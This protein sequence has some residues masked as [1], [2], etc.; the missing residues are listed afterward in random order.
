MEYLLKPKSELYK[1]YILLNCSTFHVLIIV[2]TSL[3][4]PG[5]R[6]ESVD[7]HRVV[8]ICMEE[9]KRCQETSL[10]IAFMALLGDKYGWRPLPPFILAKDLDTLLRYVK[11]SDEAVVREWYLL[12]NNSIPPTYCLQPMSTKFSVRSDNK[13]ERDQA[14]RDWGKV[15]RCIWNCLKS[16][17]DIA[18]AEIETNLKNAF[19]LSVTHMEVEKGILHSSPTGQQPL[20]VDRHFENINPND[21]KAPD[22]ID[23]KVKK[24]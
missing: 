18:E 15:E 14:W 12:D 1:C 21:Q 13:D 16:A 22:F 11:P 8:N 24:Y 6:Q 19:K 4:V 10:G 2:V 17:A 3:S 7:D 9:I 5:V 23:I 20:V